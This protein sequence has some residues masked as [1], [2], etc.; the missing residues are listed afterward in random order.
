MKKVYL[1]H[2]AT[3]PLD[4]RVFETMKPYFSERFGNASSIHRY[5]QEAKAA[6]DESRDVL[7]RLLGVQGGEIVFVAGGTEADNFA[8]KGLAAEMRTSGKKH[9]IITSKAEHH[10]VLD[11]CEY[12]R[13]NG[14]EITYVDVD[15]FGI[16][17][18]EEVRR[19]IKPETGLISIMHA[20]NE[21]G[22]INPVAEIARI[23]REHN[24]VCHS[25]AVQSFGKIPLNAAVLGPDALSLSAH[26]I[27]GPKGI[28]A[29]V[30]RKGVRIGRFMHGGG[31]ERG[32][33]AG[34]ENV[35]LAVGFAKA[36][37]LI[38]Q[39][40][41]PEHAR[42]RVLNIKFRSMLEEKLPH[43]VFNGHPTQALPHILNAS[44][45][46]RKITIDGESLLFNLDL[47]GIAVTSG[48][49]CTSGSIEPSHV[50]LAMGRDQKTAQ[51]TIRFSMG[52]STSEEDIEYTVDS[53]AKIV[54]RIGTTRR[55]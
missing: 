29:L 5:G 11:T 15:E 35:A 23:A 6:L 39:Q 10:A 41:E 20:N 47:A 7:A 54:Q 36:A 14:L 37:E 43:V 3:T 1:D 30:L 8:L 12:L 44:F 45:D 51:A 32:R 4:P 40:R 46:S 42:L 55:S 2:T 52:Q 38:T 33:R 53:L 34:T 9:H 27:Y 18:P 17:D 26:K 16:V 49:A 48:S 19:N 28:G 24:V 13:S 31:Q 21:V 25:D 50:L 22:S